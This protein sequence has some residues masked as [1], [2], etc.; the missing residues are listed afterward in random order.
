ML[1]RPHWK[2]DWLD[3]IMFL[4]KDEEVRIFASHYLSDDDVILG[5]I[6]AEIFGDL[7]DFPQR[8]EF[9]RAEIASN[10][11]AVEFLDSLEE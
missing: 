6:M 8:F 11:R 9:M 3:Y 5:R 10:K 7:P 4:S 2:N 1:P